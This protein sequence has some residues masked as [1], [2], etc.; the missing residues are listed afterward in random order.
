MLDR[1]HR[2]V[3]GIIEARRVRMSAG[4]AGR[5]HV[6]ARL[7][8]LGERV[9]D[10][11]DLG[12]DQDLVALGAPEPRAHPGLR[13]S[14][15]VMRRG[16]EHLDPARER[17]LNRRDRRFFVEQLIEVAER[18]GPLADDRERQP[19]AVPSLDASRFH[20]SSTSVQRPSSRSGWRHSAGLV[21]NRRPSRQANK[22]SQAEPEPEDTCNHMAP[23]PSASQP[24]LAAV[25]FPIGQA[26][27]PKPKSAGGCRERLLSHSRAFKRTDAS[28]RFS[29][30]RQ[31]LA[32]NQNSRYNGA[33]MKRSH[34]AA[35]HEAAT[36]AKRSR[37]PGRKYLRS[38]KKLF[39]SAVIV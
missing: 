18:A 28:R 36:V 9:H 15:A 25:A 33:C 17:L 22:E 23:G 14:V 32:E 10:A 29:N 26:Y 2:A 11:A 30:F 38:R 13:Q 5:H 19:L 31:F 6:G 4:E 37:I 24:P 7:G 8:R 1:A 16:V 27:A 35:R 21:A 3:I 20:D 39:E 34:F 12:R